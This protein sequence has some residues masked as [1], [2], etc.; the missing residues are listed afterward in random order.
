MWSL[1]S[2]GL[3]TEVGRIGYFAI[4]RAKNLVRLAVPASALAELRPT[5]VASG[6][7]EAGAAVGNK[8]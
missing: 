5:L 3:S 8:E 2:P 6:C 4:T 1:K 7:Q